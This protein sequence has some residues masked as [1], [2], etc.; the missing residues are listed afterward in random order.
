ERLVRICFADYD[1]EIPLVAERRDPATGQHEVLAIGRLSKLPG[2]TDGEFA[3]LVAD[4]YQ[5]RALGTEILRQLVR[6]AGDEKLARLTAEILT[7]N[8]P[9]QQICRK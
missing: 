3:L 2:T 1:R 6:I 7:D 9:M 8:L 5:G 4:P